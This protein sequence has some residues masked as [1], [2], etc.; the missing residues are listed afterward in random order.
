M[1]LSDHCKER[2][3]TCRPEI[4][5]LVEAVAADHP[6]MVLCG[7]RGKEDQHVAFEAGHSK[8]DWP[9]SRH[10]TLPSEAVDLAPLPLV[11]SDTHAFRMLAFAVKAKADALGIAIEWGGDFA[12]FKDLPHYQLHRAKV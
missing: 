7:H 1:G 5:R 11:W 12:T 2:L 3:A 10:N 4:Q 6:L 9:N 8:V